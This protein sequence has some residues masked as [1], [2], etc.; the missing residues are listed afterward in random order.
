MAQ[1][2]T[3]IDQATHA[4]TP[5][6]GQ[7]APL[8]AH[9]IV[10]LLMSR[11]QVKSLARQGSDLMITTAD[12]QMV[13]VH[14]FF[15]K[16]QAKPI[17]FHND[18]GLWPSDLSSLDTLP[19]DGNS[20]PAVVAD[21]TFTPVESTAAASLDT[22]ATA[23]DNDV[24]AANALPWVPL[25][26]AAV[27]LA[28]AASGGSSGGSSSLGVVSAPSTGTPVQ[29]PGSLSPGSGQTQSGNNAAAT[30][31]PDSNASTNSHDSTAAPD[32]QTSASSSGTSADT[33]ASGGQP[34]TQT[35]TNDT[36]VPVP[37][38]DPVTT[39][40][41]GSITVSGTAEAG[42][43]VSVIF[44]DGATVMVVVG[45][46]GHFTFTSATAE[47][48]GT[49]SA[50]TTDT[51]GQTSAAADMAYTGAAQQ[52]ADVTADQNSAASNPHGDNTQTSAPSTDGNTGGT[53]DTLSVPDN[54]TANPDGGTTQ[55]TVPGTGDSTASDASDTT[56][57]TDATI[58]TTPPQAGV[59]D[60]AG[61]TVGDATTQMAVVDTTAPT[62]AITIDASVYPNVG[63]GA[64]YVLT[65]TLNAA[66]ANGSAY[67]ASAELLQVSLDGGQTWNP[68]DVSGTSWAY[69]L[70]SL[71]ADNFTVEA[72]VV[73]VAGNAGPTVTQQVTVHDDSAIVP[74]T[75]G[76]DTWVSDGNHSSASDFITSTTLNGGDG[77]LTVSGNLG[78]ALQAGGSVQASLDGVTWT[79]ASVTGANW[80]AS[81][82]VTDGTYT[83]EARE[84]NA[85]GVATALA[86]QS[87]VV[88]NTAPTE[89]A[90]LD[91]V[92]RA[93]DSQYAAEIDY[94]VINQNNSTNHPEI[95]TPTFSGTLSGNLLSADLQNGSAAEQLQIGFKLVDSD[96][97]DGRAI[98]S[99]WV[100]LNVTDI[101]PDGQG[102]CTWSYTVP[103]PLQPYSTYNVELRVVD[104]AGNI[105]ASEQVSTL[106]TYVTTDGDGT[107]SP[108]EVSPQPDLLH[109]VLAIGTDEAGGN[110]GSQTAQRD[111][112]S[113]N[114]TLN[115]S[116]QEV[117]SGDAGKLAGA[118]ASGPVTVGGGAVF[119][120][121][122]A[123]G[124]GTGANQWQN[125]GATT[126]DGVI[127]DVYHNIAQGGNT[128]ADLLIQHGIAVI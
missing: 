7:E 102:G 10:E 96:G 85:A 89:T 118:G 71:P 116:L 103:D 84:V 54:A 90:M 93:V 42:S 47:S 28:A 120:V 36:T 88:G 101:D 83:F 25:A 58:G 57:K 14:E 115:L 114:G 82:W 61:N 65:G 53:I 48:D 92:P 104:K 49:I 29:N 95:L 17:M 108:S 2:V 41:D 78:Q 73:D 70:T 60:S 79:D 27:G 86:M 62:E 67:G 69:G 68:I 119:M 45:A 46:D 106:V 18:G 80:D 43:T 123:E 63:G 127:Y 38:L 74:I 125:T 33:G 52:T 11:A 117:L 94:W 50:T 6:T 66:L 109:T 128:V 76:T 77:T 31:S 30:T 98:T 39:H 55:T 110:L 4:A 24:G 112:V 34:A 64:S 72:R 113:I 59:V 21:N 5:V 8:S 105:T 75:I 3:V 111:E 37:T 81:F 9:S 87:I 12:G 19:D 40:A 20:Y 121:H 32:A 44:P 23:A 56:G 1:S 15:V 16:G 107:L 35:S 91:I 126:V 26:L 124:V 99:D 51:A 13:V 122:L 100:W 97:S 22:P